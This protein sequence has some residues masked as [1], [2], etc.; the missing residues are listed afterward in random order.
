MPK[1]TLNLIQDKI[2]HYKR[3][4]ERLEG[5]LRGENFRY[6][7]ARLAHTREMISELQAIQTN[8]LLERDYREEID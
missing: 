6:A 5:D 7:E 1:S 8:L 3:R 2:G 4:Q